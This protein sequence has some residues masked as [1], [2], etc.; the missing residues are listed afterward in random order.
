MSHLRK[1]HRIFKFIYRLSIVLCVFAKR[2]PYLHVGYQ[3]ITTLA[4]LSERSS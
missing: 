1:V 3:E 4:I 2:K